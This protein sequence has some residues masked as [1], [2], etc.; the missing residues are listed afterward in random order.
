MCIGIFR[1]VALIRSSRD[2]SFTGVV[3]LQ[4]TGCNA[5]KD[6][7]LTKFLK[8][9]WKILENFKEEVCNGLPFYKKEGLKIQ[10]LNLTCS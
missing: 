10:A 8:V 5:T 1:K 2:F 6:G 3:G 4:S 7:L 9:V